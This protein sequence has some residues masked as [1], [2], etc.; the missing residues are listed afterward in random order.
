[1]LLVVGTLHGKKQSGGN[2]IK[3]KVV[4]FSDFVA[5]LKAHFKLVF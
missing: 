3:P 2:K 5:L 4:E 1:M